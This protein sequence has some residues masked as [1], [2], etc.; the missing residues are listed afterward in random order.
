MITYLRVPFAEKDDAKGLGAR[1]DP[2]FKRWY[3]PGAGDRAAF[4]RWLSREACELFRLGEAG[5]GAAEE[6]CPEF[7]E[8]GPYDSWDAGPL[9]VELAKRLARDPCVL[10]L[11][12]SCW[13]CG[14]DAYAVEVRLECSYDEQVLLDYPWGPLSQGTFAGDDAFELGGGAVAAVPGLL[15]A[16]SNYELK[17]SE[18][19]GRVAIFKERFS[20]TVGEAY[21]SQGCPAC[22]ALWGDHHLG[23]LGVR[24]IHQLADGELDGVD[25]I[26]AFELKVGHRPEPA[27][28]RR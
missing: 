9:L 25:L 26:D 12:H 13:S 27:R 1:W 17:N 22:D 15:R 14:V 6:A 16:L 28:P 20:K 2:T 7:D 18:V 23:E 10:L 8:V 24:Y 11:R 3:V 4:R 19:A 21:M 5:L